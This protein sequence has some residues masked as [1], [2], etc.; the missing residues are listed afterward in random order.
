MHRDL[1]TFSKNTSNRFVEKVLT[2]NIRADDE[3]PDFAAY[4]KAGGYQ[5]LRKALGMDPK[6]IT[7][8]VKI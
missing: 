5:A 7:E 8:L 4:E 6:A 1:M 3:P 2:K